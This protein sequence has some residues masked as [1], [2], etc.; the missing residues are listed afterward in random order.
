MQPSKALLRCIILCKNLEKKFREKR[1]NLKKQTIVIN[2]FFHYIYFTFFISLF[3]P[4]FFTNIF[5][6]WLLLESKIRILKS[7]G[8]FGNIWKLQRENQFTYFCF[9]TYVE[10]Q[11]HRLAT[12]IFMSTEVLDFLSSTNLENTFKLLN[13]V[14]C[15]STSLHI[16]NRFQYFGRCEVYR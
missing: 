16:A 12:I 15:F 4:I 3:S 1:L 6:N 13:S 7:I 14:F 8:T 5:T 9:I 11:K 10:E 2:V